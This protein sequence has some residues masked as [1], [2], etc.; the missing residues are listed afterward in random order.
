[1]YRIPEEDV[2]K[3]ETYTIG[4]VGSNRK[5]DVLIE[6]VKKVAIAKYGDVK[7]LVTELECIKKRGIMRTQAKTAVKQKKSGQSKQ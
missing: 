4:T 3:L 7:S 1:M 2:D 5:D 6:D